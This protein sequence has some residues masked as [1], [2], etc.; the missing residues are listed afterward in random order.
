MKTILF[1]PL[2]RPGTPPARLAAAS[3]ARNR[4][5]RP[6]PLSPTVRAIA[7]KL[8]QLAAVRPSALVVLDTVIDG[9]LTNDHET[10][11]TR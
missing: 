1:D 5:P 8:E 3:A 11:R 4:T 2:H 7:E 6:A 10:G 9:L